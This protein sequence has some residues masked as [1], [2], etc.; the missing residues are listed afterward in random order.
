MSGRVPTMAEA[1]AGA[2]DTARKVVAH[3]E[4]ERYLEAIAFMTRLI[5]YAAV[6]LSLTPDQVKTEKAMSA[7]K[8][9]G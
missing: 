3:I 9:G 5:D 1:Q 2:V 7:A 8:D 4:Q 6:R